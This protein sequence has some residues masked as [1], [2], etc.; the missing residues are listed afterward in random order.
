MPTQ[1]NLPIDIGDIQFLS[2]D[3]IRYQNGQAVISTSSDS[4]GHNKANRVIQVEPNINGGDGY[5]VTIFN[6]DGNHPLW[7]NNIQMA[8]KQMKIVSVDN[9]RIVLRGYGQDAMGG[10]FADYGLTI[11]HDGTEAIK[12]KLHMHDRNV[13]IEYFKSNLPFKKEP[14]IVSLAKQAA[15]EYQK[16]NDHEA[17]TYL[18]EIYNSLKSNPEQLRDVSDFKALGKSFVLMLNPKIS[19]DIDVLQLIATLGYLCISKAIESDQ[20]NYNLYKDRLLL[21]RFGHQPFTYTVMSA[22]NLGGG[23]LAAFALGNP[24]LEARDAIYK[25]EIAD[26]EFNPILY[27]QVDFFKQRRDEFD[28][29]IARQ[30]F[31]PER[32]KENVVKTGVDTHKKLLDYVEN[33]VINEGDIDF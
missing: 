3:H 30:F 8:P 29:M 26:L 16:E 15:A 25:M 4:E 24:G 6:K 31:M 5:T 12:L 1:I 17:S 28:Q 19:N 23:G 20:K 22:L 10:A 9:Q 21:L 32:T 33:R 2:D 18:L 7:G 13:D 11:Y 27:Q 14:R